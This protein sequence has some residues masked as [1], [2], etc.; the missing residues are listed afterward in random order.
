M[1]DAV[2]S[3]PGIT[4]NILKRTAHAELSPEGL[5]KPFETFGNVVAD[6][7]AVAGAT[8]PSAC[9]QRRLGEIHKIEALCSLVLGRLRPPNGCIWTLRRPRN[10]RPQLMRARTSRASFRPP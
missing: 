7:L 6:A 10:D 5:A 2:R 8:A 3:K 1:G 4:L 9:V